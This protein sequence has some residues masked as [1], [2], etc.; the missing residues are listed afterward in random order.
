MKKFFMI[1]A[2][3]L[4]FCAI[5]CNKDNGENGGNGGSK[6]QE[7]TVAKD[8]LVFY[9]S[10]ENENATVGD[11]TLN[12]KGECTADNFVQGRNGKC[13]QGGENQYLLYDVAE[14]S[15]IRTMKAFTLSAWVKQPEIP[16]AQAPTPLYFQI[17][18]NGETPDHFWGNLSFS[19]DRTDEGAG[20]LTYKTC[21]YHGADGSIW[22][23]WNG[24]YADCYPAG[25]WNHLIFMYDNATSL[26]HVYVNGVEVTPDSAKAC[27]MSGAPAGDLAFA[28]ATQV[29]VGAWLPKVV[30]GATDEW[31]GWM[32]NSQID[33]LRLFNRALTADEASELYKAEVAN[34]D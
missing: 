33:E 17:C 31:M 15:A 3:A 30:D 7:I 27:E 21:F 12:T 22:K 11:V 18:K 28:D 6:K 24:D 29:V 9:Q 25:R 14:N 2:A 10:F 26:Y 8:A 20:Y 1:G 34:I 19:I 13:F 4:A 5:S 32:D 23:T 16:R